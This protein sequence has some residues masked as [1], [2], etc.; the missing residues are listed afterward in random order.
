[1][2]AEAAVADEADTA[3]ESFEAAVVEAEADGG[4]DAGAV[5]ADR[6]GELDERFEFRPRCP[7]KPR[8][9][10]RLR[11]SRIVKLV[12]Q[13]ELFL[14]QEGAEHR[15]VRL[16]DLGEQRELRDGLLGRR[17]EQRPAG[18]LDPFALGGVGAFVGVP[19]VAA[20]LVDGAA[21]GG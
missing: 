17:L 10:V 16:L 4:E 6:W 18:S 21:R 13:S 20:D 1:M 3:V 7:G 2:E 14:E 19:L 11:Q 15:L 12:E 9:E 8:V 5:A